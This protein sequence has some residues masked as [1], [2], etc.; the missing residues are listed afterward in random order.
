MAESANISLSAARGG[1]VKGLKISGVKTVEEAE[2]AMRAGAFAIGLIS[3]E[4]D[5]PRLGAGGLMPDER[6]REICDYIR[7]VDPGVWATLVTSR[8]GGAAIADHVHVTHANAVRIAGPCSPR[9]W[10]ILRAAHPSV[11]IIQEID[12]GADDALQLAQMADGHADALLL[13]CGARGADAASLA[14]DWRA[15]RVIAADC[16]TPVI[17]SGGLR[18]ENVDA[19]VEAV[20]PEGVAA[21]I[22][23]SEAMGGGVMGVDEMRAIAERFAAAHRRVEENEALRQRN[24]S[25]MSDDDADPWRQD[26]EP[27]GIRRNS[28][29]A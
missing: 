2:A 11:K 20:R 10:V 26:G 1:G 8:R 7:S 18:A 23:R 17:L 15:G 22:V 27:A 13:D 3:A 21:T 12:P 5:A 19:A 29:D 25:P 9:D 16:A 6:I 24:N 4:I 14:A 28:E